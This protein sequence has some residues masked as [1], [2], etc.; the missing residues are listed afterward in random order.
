MATLHSP[1]IEENSADGC[2]NPQPTQHPIAHST[3]LL[4]AIAEELTQAHKG[5]KNSSQPVRKGRKIRSP[6]KTWRKTHA[7]FENGRRI[8]LST[9]SRTREKNDSNPKMRV[10]STAIQNADG[11][12]GY[13]TY[14]SKS[15]P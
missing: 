3:Q 14:T 13:F 6:R 10:K 4:N 7:Q 1:K 8:G 2:G 15:W 9:A 11:N 5:E 12:H